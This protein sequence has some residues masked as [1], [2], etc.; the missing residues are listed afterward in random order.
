[1]DGALDLVIEYNKQHKVDL[2]VVTVSTVSQ[3]NPK[4]VAL[5]SAWI[6][7]P[8]KLWQQQHC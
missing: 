7:K 2:N 8:Q 6:V 4:P 5:Q 3:I 1:M